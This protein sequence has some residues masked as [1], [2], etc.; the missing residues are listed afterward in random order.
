MASFMHLVPVEL[1]SFIFED[2]IALFTN[3]DGVLGRSMAAITSA[4]ESGFTLRM[5]AAIGVLSPSQIRGFGT[6][7]ESGICGIL[8]F[9]TMKL[10]YIKELVVHSADV[11]IADLVTAIVHSSL[12]PSD[13]GVAI[14]IKLDNIGV[15]GERSIHLLQLSRLNLEDPLHL[16]QRFLAALCFRAPL[17]YLGIEESYYPC[18]DTSILLPAL[19]DVFTTFH[20][21]RVNEAGEFAVDRPGYYSALALVT[22]GG[23]RTQEVSS[24][25]FFVVS[26]DV[27]SGTDNHRSSLDVSAQTLAFILKATPC[28]QYLRTKRVRVEDVVQ[29]LRPSPVAGGAYLVPAP[30]LKD[31]ALDCIDFLPEDQYGKPSELKMFTSLLFPDSGGLL[32]D[33]PLL[34]RVGDAGPEAM[35]QTFKAKDSQA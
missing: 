28:I 26:L 34:D 21:L 12:T 32:Y 9:I 7:R 17:E 22:T 33:Y 35:V 4:Y 18:A 30:Q 19:Q 16:C 6:M 8:N 29:V 23:Y 3:Q 27:V 11:D 5:S 15:L 14:V 13:S 31:L 20:E 1:M 10:G 24:S 2:C 25:F